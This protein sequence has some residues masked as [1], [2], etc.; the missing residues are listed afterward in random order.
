MNWRTRRNALKSK[1]IKRRPALRW[2]AK[3][4]DALVPDK[5]P[6]PI[7]EVRRQVL[8]LASQVTKQGIRVQRPVPAAADP[9]RRR[10]RG[11]TE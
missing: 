9:A 8:L 3:G 11:A 5:L 10:R 4:L 7:E 1:H 2:R 6:T